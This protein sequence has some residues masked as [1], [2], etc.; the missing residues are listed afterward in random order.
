[1]PPTPPDRSARE[2]GDQELGL[3]REITRRDFVHLAGAGLA[4]LALSGCAR[5]D[6][7]RLVS[8]RASDPWSD[9][10]GAEWYGYGGVGDYATSHGNTPGVVRA[11]HRLRDARF[12]IEP[13]GVE[14]EERYDLVIVGGGLA[15][16]S[17]AHHFRRLHPGGRCLVLD[18]HPV[19]GG[20]AK[21]NEF[22]VEGVHLIG[23][24]GSND[25]SVPPATGGPDDY[26]T[27]LGIP[28]E[29]E[30]APWDA[31]AE[32]IRV[33]LENFGFMHWVQDR[34]SVGHF[35]RTGAGGRWVRDLWGRGL[36]EAPWPVPVRVGFEAWRSARIEDHW[37]AGARAPG[38]VPEWLDSLTL[39]Q[40]YEERLGLPPEVTAYVD[41]ILASII[42]LGCD[43]ISAWWGYHFALPGFGTPS[44]YD[45]ITF[46]SFPGGNAGIA[47]YFA[48][49]LVP[50]AISGGRALGD[51]I[52]GAI[53]FG[54]L[55]RPGQPVRLRLSST[56]L[57][58][59]HAGVRE[60]AERVRVTY[61]R[62]GRLHAVEA[63]GVVMASGGWVNRHTLADLPASY[64]AA[65]R[66]FRHAPVLV[67]NVALRNW[68]FL[69]RLG[70]AACLYQGDFGFSC[71]IRR[72][73]YAGA[74][75]PPFGPDRPAVLTFYVPFFF[76]GA[77][78][79][80]QGVRG[81]TE[82]LSTP[83]RTYERRL[84]EQMAALFG[85]AGF[86]PARDIA[87]I[88][89]NRW[90]HAYVAPGPGFVYGRNGEPAPS[91]ILRAPFG[92]V[93]IGHSELRGHQNWTGA[94]GEG[95]RAVEAI[96]DRIA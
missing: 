26:F 7:D 42:G 62:E 69:R 63:S 85:E 72:P 71:N 60:A 36:A 20:E 91:D 81:R 89:L 57:R 55:D 35:F 10:L 82:L 15:G 58:V 30:Y 12:R 29:F 66:E 37:P 94:A 53:D 25:F 43:A 59:E 1:M 78:P 40:Y 45:G 2:P 77:S 18:N 95:R 21:R 41:P 51:V 84:R 47:R 65:Y 92:R 14:A 88:I 79:A 87:G 64:R 3:D 9:A 44:R 74:Y 23:P 75:R 67:A 86:D 11:G 6:S 24:Q 80:D 16:L 46:H 90:G 28:R 48:K 8:G 31:D 50:E 17:A 13:G 5:G 61:V 52:G 22:E 73:M 96:L 83:F 76:P 70:I 32:G 39:K 38:E 56:A 4:G 54:A 93:A 68:R 27:A 34:F 19:F 49:S 33:P